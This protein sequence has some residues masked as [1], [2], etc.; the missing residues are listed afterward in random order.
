LESR[1]EIKSSMEGRNKCYYPVQN[2]GFKTRADSAFE[3]YKL[4][5]TQERIL[6]TIK[7]NPWITQKTLTQS[8]GMK[9]FTIKYN[10]KKLIDFG[11]IQKKQNGRNSCY[12]HITDSEL[13]E[14]IMKRLIVKLLKHEIDEHT[15][16]VLKRKLETD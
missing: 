8:T 14:Q 15:F 6:D 16:L 9:N 5:D 3:T 1:K 4:N 10:L 12:K 2:I 13:R 7:R 11:V